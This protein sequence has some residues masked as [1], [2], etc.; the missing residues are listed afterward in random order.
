MALDPAS[1]LG[2][3]GNVIEFV[4]FVGKI[5]SGVYEIYKSED[6]ALGEHTNLLETAAQLQHTNASLDK[7]LHLNSL[8]KPL[9]ENERQLQ[10]LG[11][12]CQQVSSDLSVAIRNLKVQSTSKSWRSFRQALNSV[13]SQEKIDALARRLDEVRKQVVVC[14]LVSLR[15]VLNY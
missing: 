11:Q 14:V 6:E 1:A 4:E 7:S 5:V 9:T 10:A 2:V 3:A 12:S 15:F 8:G 13:W